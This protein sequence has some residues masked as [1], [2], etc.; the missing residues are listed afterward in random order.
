MNPN[1]ALH[2]MSAMTV[3]SGCRRPHLHRVSRPGRA[4]QGGFSLVV[5]M[6]FLVALSLLAVIAVRSVITSDR[7]AGNTQD[8]NLAFQAA[9][10]ALRDGEQDVVGMDATGKPN[11]QPQR[12]TGPIS[13][14]VSFNVKCSLGLCALASP[15]N[16]GSQPV[17]STAAGAPLA[18][19]TGW[20]AG[21]TSN[22]GLSVSYGTYTT[23]QVLLDPNTNAPLPY[24]PH[25]IIEDLG[26][27]GSSGSLTAGSG[28]GKGRPLQAYRVTAVGF[29]KITTANGT[30]A[31]RV[32]LQSI[33]TH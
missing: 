2:P 15:L 14:N 31:T 16:F 8:W 7:M 17:W 29:G 25:Y 26:A 33:I 3:A 6:I 24:Q 12:P 23:G 11:S 13:S 27:P 4:R 20:T 10:A 18:G 32:V 19:D 1:F 28:Y 9:E 30:P 22:G 5:G 21:A